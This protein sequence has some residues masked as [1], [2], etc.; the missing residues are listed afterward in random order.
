MPPKI[1]IIDDEPEIVM[2]LKTLLED[3]GYATV[4]APDGVQGLRFIKEEKPDLVCID[5]MMPRKTGIALYH[6]IKTDPQIKEIP[7]IL[8]S[9]YESAY[10]FKGKSFRRL[11]QDK[12]IPEP[13]RYFE[14][15]IDVKAFLGFMDE[16]FARKTPGP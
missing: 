6:E 16:H 5:I 9:A 4:S 14:K 3:H 12:S 2:Y 13:L 15:P 10:A 7:V 8:I 11:V 1:M